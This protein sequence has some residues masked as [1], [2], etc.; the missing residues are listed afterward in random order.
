MELVAETWG[1]YVNSSPSFAWEQN[2]KN[3]K[4]ALKK[5]ARNSFHSPTTSR[6]EKV[7]ELSEIQLEMETGDITKPQLTLKHLTKIKTSLAFCQEEE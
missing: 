7:L 6:L 5:W 2:L 3:T 1:Q 4:Y